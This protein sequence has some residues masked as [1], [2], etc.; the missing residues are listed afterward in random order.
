MPKK[1]QCQWQI[2]LMQTILFSNRKNNFLNKW[3]KK[4]IDFSWTAW[5]KFFWRKIFVMN[6]LNYQHKIAIVCEFNWLLI[7]LIC[8][9]EF[10]FTCG[11][12][13]TVERKLLKFYIV[14]WRIF[15][16]KLLCVMIEITWYQRFNRAIWSAIII[17]MNSNR[18][19]CKWP[20]RFQL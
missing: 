5:V 9:Y 1:S 15:G 6:G 17:K 8:L 18:T 13:W 14:P 19:W 16:K 20:W 3:T 7:N 2:M 4:Y 12:L 10:S 11:T